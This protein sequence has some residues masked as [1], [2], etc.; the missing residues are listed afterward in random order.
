MGRGDP[1]LSLLRSRLRNNR[2]EILLWGIPLLFVAL[3][4]FLPLAKIFLTAFQASFKNTAVPITPGQITAPL[5]FTTWQAALSTILTLILG[6]PA[7]YL[8]ARFS[9]RGKSLLKVLTTIP[10]ILPTVV[11]AAGFNALLGARGLLNLGLMNLFHLSTP[12]ITFMNTLAAILVVHVFYNTTIIIRIVGS[13]WNQLDPRWENTARVLGASKWQTLREVTLP[14]LKPSLLAATLLVFLFDFT[15]FGV[16]MLV[17]GPHFSSLE[18][19]IY[20]Q[21]YSMLNLPL[22]GALS[23]VQLGCTFLVTLVY[24]RINGNRNFPLL[25]H[26]NGEALRAAKTR[27]EK[28]LL[29]GVTTIL[30]LILTLPMLAMVI[31]SFLRLGADRG[32]YGNFQTGFTTQYYTQLFINSNQSIFYVPPAQAAIN[33]LFYA[34]I[35]VILAISLGLV[36]AY[37]ITRSPGKAHLLNTIISLP[38]GASAVT[39]GLG[40][41]ITFNTPPFDPQSF[42]LL[43]PIAHTLVAMPF[44][45]RAVQPVLA[46]IPASLRDAASVLGASR[47]Q[48]W[49]EV[50]LPIIGRAALVGAIFSF[51]ISLGEFGATSFLAQPNRPTLP[52]A[53]AR[54]LSMPGDLN[55]GQ[56]LAM[57]TLLMLVC[58]L[59]IFALERIHLPGTSEI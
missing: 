57:S 53:I 51:T 48:V 27:I 19:A 4:F 25:P 16:I 42:P 37:A 21:V 46:S 5:W 24:T 10:F 56:A 8:F 40:F 17:G 58:A 39:L 34:L 41:L 50:E 12:P 22:A 32:E 1:A 29:Y 35:T 26:L 28:L 47:W 23:V 30:F 45:V 7:A 13:A 14:L 31:R 2:S 18:V 59:A 36:A 54:Y 33:S 44:V 55:Y 43:I 6:L 3:F 49:R 11:A 20:Q 52:I 9:F 15:S 38:L